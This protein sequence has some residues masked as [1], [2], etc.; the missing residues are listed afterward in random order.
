MNLKNYNSRVLHYVE[1]SQC[2]GLPNSQLTKL[3]KLTNN[4][5]GCVQ[6][7]TSDDLRNFYYLFIYFSSTLNSSPGDEISIVRRIFNIFLL[8]DMRKIRVLKNYT[9]AVIFS[10]RCYSWKQIVSNASFQKIKIIR[11]PPYLLHF[12]VKVIF[13]CFE[14]LE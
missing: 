2:V 14:N 8:I 6:K 1:I 11:V 5:G 13:T 10:L 9:K 4:I 12:F 3:T 7:I